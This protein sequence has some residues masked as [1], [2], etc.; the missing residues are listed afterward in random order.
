MSSA[1]DGLRDLRKD[2]SDSAHMT[3]LELADHEH[4]ITVVSDHQEAM[5]TELDEIAGYIKWLVLGV[6]GLVGLTVWEK[7]V[8]PRRNSGDDPPSGS[9]PLYKRVLG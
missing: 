3:A 7:V 2:Q 6:L 8:S 4:R 1:E 9:V 5:K